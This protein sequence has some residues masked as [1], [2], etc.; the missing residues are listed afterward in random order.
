MGAPAGLSLEIGEVRWQTRGEKQ[1]ELER[2]LA[3]ARRVV[4][5]LAWWVLRAHLRRTPLTFD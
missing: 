1:V 2:S 4:S 3:L 5:L